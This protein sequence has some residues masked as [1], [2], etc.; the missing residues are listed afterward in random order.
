[1]QLSL[2]MQKNNENTLASKITMCFDKKPKKA[3]FLFGNL[4]ENGFKI[5]EEEL[6]DTS[7]KYYFAIG[8]DKK[9]TTRIMLDSILN[10]SKD[11]YYYSNNGLVEFTSNICI[12]EY[13]NEVYMYVGSSNMSESGIQEDLSLYSEIIFDLNNKED[14]AE[15]KAQV[16][17]LTKKIEEEFTKLNK[18][19]INK[20]VEEKEIFTTRQYN[21]N[22]KSISELLN[23]SNL[24]SAKKEMSK[25]EIDDV[26]VQ[27]KEI[28]KVDL[29]DLSLDID[30][31]D[32]E[33]KIVTDSSTK[34]IPE[35]KEEIE[36]TYDEDDFN[37]M[38]NMD[39]VKEFINSEN[40]ENEEDEIKLDVNNEYYDASMA[41]DEI[42]TDA[43]IDISDILFSKADVK[44]DIDNIKKEKKPIKKQNEFDEE[45]EKVQ[46]KKVNLNNISNF[47]FELP[48]RPLKEQDQNV[49]KVP[50]Y[51]RT[52][53][54]EFFGFNEK[55]KNVEINGVMYKVRNIK[56]EVVDVGT[57]AKYTDRDAKIMYKN[58][59]TYLTFSSD[60]F[61]NIIYSEKDIIRIIKLAGDIYHI[62]IIPKDMQEYKLWSKICNQTFKAT[63]RKYGM[64]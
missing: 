57:G 43:T 32:V 31:S 21:H 5:L 60:T 50:N 12:F 62:E 35:E 45:D 49:I 25:E 13:T 23:G 42:D 1:M 16:K 7:T 26:Y 9:N 30:L 64:M 6:I 38:S 33:E 4:K 22:V 53:I 3:Y 8:V 28:P 52:M 27:D 44:L 46:V 19:E 20:L 61:K 59:Q 10:Y 41:D 55:V 14:K 39:E 54:P 18:T 36:V 15:Y 47:I 24:K 37:N 11:V 17:E 34:K 51:I 2:V 63:T 56:I 29:S 40:H 48:S 58:G